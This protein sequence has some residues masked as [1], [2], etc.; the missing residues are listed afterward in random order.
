M[1][2]GLGP[3]QLRKPVFEPPIV[4]GSAKKSVPLQRLGRDERIGVRSQEIDSVLAEPTLHFA[5]RVAV[6]FGMYVLIA[7]PR[8]AAFGFG[9]SIAQ[10]RIEEYVTITGEA[11]RRAPEPVGKSGPRVVEPEYDDSASFSE[12]RHSRER[13][14]WIGRVMQNARAVDDVERAFSQP[15]TPEI[16]LDEESALDFVAP[17]GTRRERQR[18]CGDV[19]PDHDTIGGGQKK[20][21]LSGAASHLDD[22]RIAGNRAIE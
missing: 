22:R 8:L 18:R 6:L 1:R 9:G 16:R 14:A 4:F 3:A 19:R 12:F 10:H 15:G 2:Q 17:T 13:R 7:Q 11:C 21:H 20:A 5:D